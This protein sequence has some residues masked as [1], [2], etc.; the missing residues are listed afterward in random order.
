MEKGYRRRYKTEYNAWYG[1]LDR[2]Y[3]PQNASYKHYGERGIK[4]CARWRDKQTGFSNF[5][6]DVRTLGNHP[7]GYSL[8]RID[9]DG[10]Y[11]LENV[12]WASAYR[13]QNN[14]RDTR[15]IL[16]GDE[17]LALSDVAKRT[18]ICKETLYHR[19]ERGDRG[20]RL[21]RSVSNQPKKVTQLNS[22]GE[23][24]KVFCSL[25]QAG[26]SV[27]ADTSGISACCR[28]LRRTCRG[29]RW[30]YTTE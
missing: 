21:V 7:K 16:Y 22:R 26:K 30:Q 10:D 18:A 1:M 19:W 6:C 13:Q 29:F 14:R 27:G 24:I 11:C 17:M 3:N 4:V 23:V 28:G 8:D 2:C 12:R 15:K 25:H 20:N 9:V 5:L